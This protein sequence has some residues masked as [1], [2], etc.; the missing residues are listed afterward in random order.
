MRSTLLFLLIMFPVTLLAQER[1]PTRPPLNESSMD[2][3]FSHWAEQLELTQVFSSEQTQKARINGQWVKPGDTVEGIQITSIKL[4]SV[5]VKKNNE[6]VEIT[7]FKPITQKIKG[8][9]GV[10]Q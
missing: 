7:L 10:V 5:I 8:S 2:L 9:P 3:S 1:D 6:T 4:N